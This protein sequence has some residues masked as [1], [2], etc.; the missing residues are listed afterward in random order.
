MSHMC[1]F[2]GPSDPVHCFSFYREQVLSATTQ[3]RIGVHMNVG[4]NVS[5]QNIIPIQ[6]STPLY[7][8]FICLHRSTH[9]YASFVC[10]HLLIHALLF[11]SSR[12]LF[13][14]LVVCSLYFLGCLVYIYF[15]HFTF[16]FFLS[17]LSAVLF[18]VYH[19]LSNPYILYMFFFFFPVQI[20]QRETERRYVQ[21]CFDQH[22]CT[23]PQQNSTAG[24]WQW[25]YSSYCVI[26]IDDNH[27]TFTTHLIT[28]Y[29]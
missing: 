2:I 28:W 3:N 16:I 7:V 24:L 5:M 22:G 25:K 11:G 9:T 21:R 1:M 6:F 29:Q 19:L 10:S 4:E 27:Y 13:C 18:F 12:E 20:Q 14:G 23:S 15:L 17:P 8:S 26:S